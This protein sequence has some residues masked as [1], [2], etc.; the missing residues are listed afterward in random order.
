MNL[1][2]KGGFLC[3]RIMFSLCSGWLFFVFSLN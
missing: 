1:L 2:L 3:I